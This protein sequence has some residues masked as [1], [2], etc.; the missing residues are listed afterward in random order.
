MSRKR[1]GRRPDA[2]I[3]CKAWPVANGGRLPKTAF[4]LDWERRVLRCP[5]AVEMPFAP[6]ATVHFPA[7]TCA[8]C[9]LQ[10]RCAASAHGRSVT[11]WMNGCSPSCGRAQLRERVALEHTLAH[12][13]HWQTSAG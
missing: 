11:T 12:V 6:A 2:A 9:P 1:S 5:H 7:A 3:R 4:A 8:A 13:G 10:A